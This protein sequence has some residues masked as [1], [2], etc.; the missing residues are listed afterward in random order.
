MSL[1]RKRFWLLLAYLL[2]LLPFIIYGAAQA[3]Q[4][5]V[6][7]PLD[8]VDNS[9]PARADYDQFSQLFGNS[10]TVIVSWSGCTIHNPDLDPF[11]N[12]LRT[13][14]VF[15]DEQD[16]WYFERVISGRELYR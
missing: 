8:W 11:V 16:E 9:F 2:L 10:D 7:S 3:M 6:N 14:A 13:D 12:S 4:T 5:K 15:R 1:S